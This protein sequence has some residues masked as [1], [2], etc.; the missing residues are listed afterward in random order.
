MDE[1]RE[2][3]DCDV[4]ELYD[5]WKS[6]DRFWAGLMRWDETTWHLYC[7]KHHVFIAVELSSQKP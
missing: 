1:H 4:Q 6:G 7:N 5:T 2:K 3:C